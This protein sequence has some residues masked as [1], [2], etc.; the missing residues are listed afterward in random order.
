MQE[1]PLLYLEAAAPKPDG[2]VQLSA[3]FNGTDF[4]QKVIWKHHLGDGSLEDTGLY[5]PP[6]DGALAY[7]LF[8]AVLPDTPF[9]D[10]EGHLV[11]PLNQAVQGV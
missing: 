6:D 7:A 3:S 1:E 8:T 4:T 5:S 10:L 11:H 2:S 9:G